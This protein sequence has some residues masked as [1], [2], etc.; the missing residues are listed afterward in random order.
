MKPILQHRWKLI[1]NILRYYALRFVPKTMRR[2]VR[3]SRRT[4]EIIKC[5]EVLNIPSLFSLNNIIG[6][7]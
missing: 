2:Q 1:G 5:R 7:W 4:A 3:I 6:T